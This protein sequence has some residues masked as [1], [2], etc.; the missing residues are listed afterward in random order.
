MSYVLAIRMIEKCV[1]RLQRRARPARC[2]RLYMGS[3]SYSKL[4]RVLAQCD[5]PL[6]VTKI[7]L[8][9]SWRTSCRLRQQSTAFPGRQRACL[10]LGRF[11]SLLTSSVAVC[12]SCLDIQPNDIR[13]GGVEVLR[14][15][16]AASRDHS[17]FLACNSSARSVSFRHTSIRSEV[18]TRWAQPRSSRGRYDRT[19]AGH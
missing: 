5:E 13:T 19:G 2:R 7:H 4:S 3:S 14:S 6:N 11:R 16:S 9:L 15:R 18:G 8:G 12:R 10:A 1:K 17:T